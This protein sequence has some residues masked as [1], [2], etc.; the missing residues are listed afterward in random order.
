MSSS[1]LNCLF[2]RIMSFF[3]F[4]GLKKVSKVELLSG[5]TALHFAA[6]GGHARCIRLLA[7]DVYHDFPLSAVTSSEVEQVGDQHKSLSAKHYDHL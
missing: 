2:F 5:R 1:V 3:F 6:S 7:V 4:L